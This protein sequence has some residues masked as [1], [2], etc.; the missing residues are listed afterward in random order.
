MPK[1]RPNAKKFTLSPESNALDYLEKTYEFIRRLRRDQ[2][3]WKW[4]AIALHSALY[5]FAVCALRGS[6]PDLVTR[7]VKRGR[8]H[9]INFD[10]AIRRC[11]DARHMGMFTISK[12]LKLTA[13]QRTSIAYLH[14]VRNQL[15]HYYPLHW[16]LCEQDLAA[17]AVDVL[18]VIRF[19]ALESGNVYLRSS[20]QVQLARSCTTK[21][22]ELL[23]ASQPYKDFRAAS[24]RLRGTTASQSQP[25]A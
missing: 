19:L 16:T 25:R 10:E 2:W 5:S 13:E 14:K 20:Q 4:V 8:A 18:E 3:A 15:E 22:I 12:V 24:K 6:N 11:Q 7:P 9:V 1:G 23:Q 17:A 21:S